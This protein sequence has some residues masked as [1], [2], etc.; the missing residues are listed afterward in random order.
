MLC[1]Q[2]NRGIDDLGLQKYSYLLL[3]AGIFLLAWSILTILGI[4]WGT[5]Y[6]WPDFVHTN[7][8]LPFVWGTHT[9]NT[10][11]GPVDRWS[12]DLSA[13]TLDVI[14]WFAGAIAGVLIIQVLVSTQFHVSERKKALSLI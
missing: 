1:Y 7:Y 4:T 8:G 3:P 5:T 9:L 14:L 12:V 10:I 6:Y 2:K 13:M 11:I